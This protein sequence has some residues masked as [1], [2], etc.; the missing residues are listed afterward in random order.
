MPK[1]LLSVHSVTGQARAPMSEE[2][3]RRSHEQLG[4]LEEEMQATGAWVFSGRLT[5]PDDATVVRM[6]NGKPLATDG[7]FAETRE[8]LGGFYIV[9]ADDSDAALEWASRVTAAIDVPIE[10]RPFAA[11]AA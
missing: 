5:E 3:M 6:S 4:Q 10:V 8:H 7:P 11:T 1:Y 2:Q 9:E